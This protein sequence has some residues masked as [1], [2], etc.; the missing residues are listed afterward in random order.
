MASST[1]ASAIFSTTELLEAILL[2]VYPLDIVMCERVRRS[3]RDCIAKSPELQ[4]KLFLRPGHDASGNWKLEFPLAY[5]LI[6][7]ASTEPATS[8]DVLQTIHWHQV[9][10]NGLTVDSAVLPTVRLC[11]LVVLSYPEATAIRWPTTAS[12]KTYSS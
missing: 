7:A 1:A 2:H 4:V 12:P 5:G 10:T 8:A 6:S 11:P 9:R 3:F